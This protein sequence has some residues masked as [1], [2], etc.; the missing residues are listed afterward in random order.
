MMTVPSLAAVGL[1]SL[2]SSPL[3]YCALRRV[4]GS[5]HPSRR[6]SLPA[7]RV[8]TRLGDDIE[9]RA[10][11]DTGE[12]FAAE[13]IRC[14][15]LQVVKLFQLGRRVSFAKQRQVGFLQIVSRACGKTGRVELRVFPKYT[16]INSVPIV[17]NLQQLQ[18]SVLDGDLDRCRACIERVLEQLLD[19]VGWAVD[20]L[21]K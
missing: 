1:G 7:T 17:R 16:H 19:R 6:D 9:M 14:Q 13:T 5:A 8:V 4:S 15:R 21:D 12:C 18:P 2:L 3:E 20:D 11:A 10:V